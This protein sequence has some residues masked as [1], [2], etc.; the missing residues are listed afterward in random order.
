MELLAPAGTMENFMAA[1]EAG[2][3]A[4]FLGGKGFNAR[5]HANNFAIEELGEAVK[6]AHLLG[7][8]VYVTVNIVVGDQELKELAHYLRELERIHVDAIIVQD[9]AVAE[10]AKRVAP[11]LH[12]H[13]STQMTV[14]NLASVQY[15]GRSGFSRVVLA[16]EVSLEEIRHI[17]SHT[18]VEIEVFIHGALCICYSGQCLMSSFI[19]GRSGNRGSCAQ[20]CRLPYTLVDEKGN[21][22]IHSCQGVGPSGEAYL[23]SPKD[24][25]YS[26][27]MA[28]LMEAGVASFKVEGRMKKVSY[29]RNIIGAYRDIIDQAGKR[30]VSQAKQLEEGFN[31]GFSTAYLDNRA[32]RSMMTIAA[33]NNQ[34]KRI[35]EARA[36]GKGVTL[37]FTEM[38]EK[39]DLLKVISTSGQ[40][41]YITLDE[42][43]K[44][45]SD[46]TFVGHPQEG[47]LEGVVYLASKSQKEKGFRGLAEFARK[48]PLYAYLEGTEGETVSLTLLTDKGQSITVTNDYELQIAQKV[49]TSLEKITA[50]LGRLGNTVFSLSHVSIPDGP[51]MWPTSVLNELRREAIER[52]E[53]D[54]DG[55][56]WAE[57]KAIELTTFH[58]NPRV[59]GVAD[60]KLKDLVAN[61]PIVSI[62]L[63][64]LDQVKA[65]I[66]SGAKKIIFGGDRWKRTPYDSSIYN[67]VGALC[68]KAQVYVS[69][70]T[71]RVVRESE[72][73]A[74][75]Q[76]LAA[77]VAAQPDSISIHFLGALVWLEELG[78]QG[79]VE[80]DTSLQVFNSNALAYLQTLGL[81]SV[82]LSQEA[83]LHQIRKMAQSLSMPL[84]A[85]VQG[86]TELMISEYCV[87]GS[88]LGNGEKAN[89]PQP[90]QQ[91]NYFLQDRKG[92][93]FPL[94][95]DPYCR[96]HILN[97]RELDMMP[98][99][100]ELRTSG[101]AMLRIEGR[102]R[103]IGYITSTVSKYV[104]LLTGTMSPPRKDS[105]QEGS[106]A[107]TRGHYFKGIF[108]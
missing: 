60:K 91:K 44:K 87:I 45:K 32:G 98:Y 83:T 102:Q 65:A 61:G 46:W 67:E 81:Q 3:D 14:T 40:V 94:R 103:D 63:D 36:S 11:K 106:Q 92:E 15:L 74:Y 50:Q 37:T 43:W 85:V 23:M 33:P 2:A 90:C 26:A 57:K 56:Y 79:S 66:D 100:E 47:A 88:F 95:T 59:S 7:V 72:S 42:Q 27:H 53:E 86:Q 38:P 31:R 55:Q 48:I 84:E 24:L 70:S 58:N 64:E 97:S 76:T 10:I 96:M 107:I 78:Y 54:L 18:D 108:E 13:G 80:G 12:L 73:T 77:M 4:I 16:R 105:S 17:C 5:S 49:P 99:I 68:R 1:L 51:Y 34:G 9:L 104:Q 75:K 41:V 28:E 30:T 6:L 20:P 35:G 93:H 21:N 29:V 8:Q 25:N 22:Q 39:G 62:H 89:C 52:L 19:G 101:L 82:A 69:L 71:P